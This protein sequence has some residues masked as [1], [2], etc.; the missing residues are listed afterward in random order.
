MVSEN[1]EQGGEA[2]AFALGT[3][4]WSG[5]YG[6]SN[7]SGAPEFHSAAQMLDIAAHAGTTTLDTARGYGES[8]ALIGACLDARECDDAFEVITKLDPAVADPDSTAAQALA[9]TG[10]S[11]AQSRRALGRD[12]LDVLLLHRAAHLEAFDGAIWRRLLREREMGTIRALGVSAANPAEAWSAL[13]HPEVEVIQVATSL[14]DQRLARGDYFE[15]AAKA[16]KRVFVRSVFLQGLA[17]VPTRKLPRKLSGFGEP[18]DE[19]RG[20]S[21]ALGC[22]V[23]TLFLSYVGSLPGCTAVLGCETVEQLRGLV[24]ATSAARPSPASLHRLAARITSLPDRLLDPSQWPAL[25]PPD[26]RELATA[27]AA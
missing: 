20:T 13:Q 19:I 24:E 4:Q 15:Q 17:F 26:E 11:L 6:I 23:E 21:Q 9:N 18:L 10:R 8:E 7:C 25:A 27:P 1:R 22:S 5:H 3:A 16:E 12:E 14:L 2:M